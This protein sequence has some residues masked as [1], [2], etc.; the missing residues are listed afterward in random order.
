MFFNKLFTIAI[1][2]FNI[3]CIFIVLTFF[4]NNNITH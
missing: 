2:I 1:L 4:K 3:K